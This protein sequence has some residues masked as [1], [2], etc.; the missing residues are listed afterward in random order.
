MRVW[1]NE[2]WYYRCEHTTKCRHC[3]VVLAERFYP[4]WYQ[5]NNTK[6]IEEEVSGIELF[7][8]TRDDI[9]SWGIKKFDHI[10]ILTKYIDELVKGPGNEREGQ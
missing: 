5:S 10:K 3:F 8:V 1:Q 7:Q 9:K 6:L 4:L 2:T